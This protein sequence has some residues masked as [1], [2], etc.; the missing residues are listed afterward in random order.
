MA[1]G[2]PIKGKN[3]RLKVEGKTVYHATECSWSTT[4]DFEE[5]AS[6]DTVGKRSIPGD[7]EF[8]ASTAALIVEKAAGATQSDIYD[9]LELYKSDTLVEIEFT[10]DI[11]GTKVISGNY[12]IQ[13]CD[14][15]AN[16]T[17]VATA[18][19]S[20]RGDGDFSIETVA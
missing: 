7:Y 11:A 10:T 9:L 19:C 14:I 17:G 15:S 12:Y 2:D 20:F 8:S 18:N 3:L 1:A 5:F 16:N 13:A 6:K 4:K